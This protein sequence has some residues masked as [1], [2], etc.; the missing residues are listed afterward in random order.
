VEFE[1][2]KVHRQEQA[3]EWPELIVNFKIGDMYW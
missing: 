1:A 2:A 3:Q